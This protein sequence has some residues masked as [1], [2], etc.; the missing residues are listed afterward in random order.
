MTGTEKGTPNAQK[1]KLT[2]NQ[3]IMI[4]GFV[5]IILVIIVAAIILYHILTKPDDTQ[6]SLVIDAS[7]VEAVTNELAERVAD[8]MFEVNMNTVWHFK[9]A[10][11]PSY[12]AVLANLGSN[13]Y[14]ISFD[15][16]LADTEET[17]FTSTVIP[18]GSQ[19]KEI[20]LDKD[21]DAGTYNAICK[22]HLLREDGTENSSMSVNI[23]LAVEN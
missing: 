6:G 9:D 18:I 19:I 11:E 20:K 3:K 1:G 5:A 13:N 16:I 15:V 2:T 22:Y 4:G 10:S 14:A 7:N 17:V 8:G 21:L 23:T 12:D